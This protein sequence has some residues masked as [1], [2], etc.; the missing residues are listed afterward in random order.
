MASTF[1]YA[2]IAYY[3]LVSLFIANETIE[4]APLPMW[5]IILYSFRI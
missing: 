3:F 5:D 2:F 4:N 1:S